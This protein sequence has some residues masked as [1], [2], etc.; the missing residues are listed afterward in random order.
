MVVPF[1]PGGSTDILGRVVAQRIGAT[2]GQQVVV[3]NRPGAGGSV[4]TELIA[5]SGLYA[6]L[7]ALQFVA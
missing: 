3:E 7:A 4:G 2:L 6:R 1:T 5:R